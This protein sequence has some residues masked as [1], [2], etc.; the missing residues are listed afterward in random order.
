[1]IYCEK[2]K[3]IPL[4]A[5]KSKSIR[6]AAKSRNTPSMK[7]NIIQKARKGFTTIELVAVIVILAILGAIG[8]VGA[9]KLRQ[10][11]QVKAGNKNAEAMTKWVAAAL[12]NGSTEAGAYSNGTSS[13]PGTFRDDT[14][15][16]L[17]ADATAGVTGYAGPVA[18]IWPTGTPATAA[19][20]TIVAAVGNKPVSVTYN[21]TDATPLAP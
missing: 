4:T 20:Y 7:Q 21:G 1:M 17:I 12:Q 8:A 19:S 10:A 15:A 5:N 3:Q 9:V 18:I 2:S 6:G 13:A 14:V 11:A 16:N